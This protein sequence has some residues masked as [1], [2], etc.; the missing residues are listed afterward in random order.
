MPQ[1]KT[2]RPL[3]PFAPVILYAV[4]YFGD[5][6]DAACLQFGGIN[7]TLATSITI[8][9]RGGVDQ[10]KATVFGLPGSIFDVFAAVSDQMSA[11]LPNQQNFHVRPLAQGTM[12]D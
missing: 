8:N 7:S 1:Y 4:C 9:V 2:V 12:G 6:G 11:G 10:N 3:K 5:A